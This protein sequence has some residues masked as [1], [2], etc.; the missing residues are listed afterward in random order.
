M[1]AAS[2][3]PWHVVEESLAVLSD[4]KLRQQWPASGWYRQRVQKLL[5][6][7]YPVSVS[8]SNVEIVVSILNSWQTDTILQI[9]EFS[10][11][12]F[13]TKSEVKNTIV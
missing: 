11:I 2:G 8:L 3:V 4:K 13:T 1:V 12:I 10:R 6:T 5:K 9:L 7:W